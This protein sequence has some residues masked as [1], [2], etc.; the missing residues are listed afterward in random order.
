M[1]QNKR[2]MLLG[3]NGWKAW[4]QILPYV[5]QNESFYTNTVL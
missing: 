5:E 1:L 3:L 2:S 4:L